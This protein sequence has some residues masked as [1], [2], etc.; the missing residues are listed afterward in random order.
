MSSFY[1]SIGLGMVRWGPFLSYAYKL[2][3]LSDD[4]AFEVGPSII[5]ELGWCSKNQNVSLPQVHSNS[6]HC[7]IGGHICHNVFCKVVTKHQQVHHT[8]GWSNSIVV[9]MLVKSTCNN[10]KGVV[11]M[12]G[13]M[14]ALAWMPSC[15]MHCSQLL[16]AFFIWMA[17]SGHQNWSC[18]KHYICCRPWC[19]ASQWHPFMAATWWALG[20][21]NHKTSS[22]FPLG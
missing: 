5:Q 17:M 2:T 3:M 19:P 22:S 8:W 18:S 15:W 21:M 7:L 1:L 13:H 9:S 11:T 10:S 4:V 20:T 6:S 14:G 12:M 16:I